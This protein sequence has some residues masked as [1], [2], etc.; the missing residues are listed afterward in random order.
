VSDRRVR[1]VAPGRVNLIGDHT[2]HMGGPV[3]PM[4]IQLGTTVEGVRTGTSIELAS[5]RI[6]GEVRVDLP[7]TDPARMSPDWGRYVAGVALQLAT[8]VGLVGRVTSDLPPG[9]GLSSSAALE[10]ATALALRDEGAATDPLELARACQL[11]EQAATGVPCG[12]MD[13]LASIAG[14]EGHA[15]LID[16]TTLAVEPV[17]VPD[18]ARVWVVHSG[19]ERTLAGSAYGTRRAEC[20]RAAAELGPLPGADRAAVERLADPVVRARARHVR[21]ESARVHEFAAALRDEDLVRAGALMDASHRSLRDDFEVS[22]PVLDELVEHLRAIPGVHGARLTGA[23]FGGCAVA[24]AE[25]GVR[26]HGW[27]VVPSAGARLE[28]SD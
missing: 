18:H 2:D 14:I 12:I 9:A 27:Q 5:D 25:P 10:V 3:L 16:C 11:A 22:T 23:G 17:P 1:S 19:Q 26:L 4:A 13:Q 15:L 7:V 28:P 8:T 6:D 20:E 24:L 21:S